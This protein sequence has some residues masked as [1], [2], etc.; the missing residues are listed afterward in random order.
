MLQCEQC[1]YF[2]RDETTGRVTL[3]CNPFTTVKEPECLQKLQLLRLD[4]L[5]QSYQVM[6]SWYQKLA[7]MQEKM[8]KMMKREIDDIDEADSWKDA[9]DE[10]ADVE[11][12]DDDDDDDYLIK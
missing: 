7:P 5:F 8:F 9:Y 4:G 2:S 12:D 10:D 1:E 11:F 3:L 6:I